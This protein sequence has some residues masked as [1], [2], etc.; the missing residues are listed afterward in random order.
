MVT[1][2]LLEE[3]PANTKYL[4]KVA[5]PNDRYVNVTYCE[6]SS[7]TQCDI[8]DLVTNY[9]SR[10]I[11]WISLVTLHGNCLWSK[12][13]VFSMTESRLLPP[14]LHVAAHSGSVSVKVQSKPKLLKIF[15][16]QVKYTFT[17]RQAGQNNTTLQEKE[18]TCD[19]ACDPYPE[20]KFDGLQWGKEYC[21]NVTVEPLSNPTSNSTK[22]CIYLKPDKFTI[23]TFILIA[24]SASVVVLM[25]A[26]VCFFLCRPAKTPGTLKPLDTKWRPLNINQTPVEV[27]I[28]HGWFLS[29]TTPD[30]TR[31]MSEDKMAILQEEEK[32]ASLDSGVSMVVGS[33]RGSGGGRR[34]VDTETQDNPQEDS[35]CGSLGSSAESESNHG[36]SG[37]LPLEEGRTNGHRV[38]QEEDSGLGLGF[39]SETTG[40]SYGSDCG[41]LPDVEFA[42]GDG[43]RSQSPS[44]IVVGN[45]NDQTTLTLTPAEMHFD[46]A[47][48]MVG[49]RPSQVNVQYSQAPMDDTRQELPVPSYLRKVQAVEAT[50]LADILCLSRQ[51][52]QTGADTMPFIVSFPQ[53]LLN[54]TGEA[55]GLAK[56]PLP[57]TNM[58]LT[59]G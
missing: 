11:V 29:R 3:V 25:L 31:E 36:G 8:S 4:V 33:S 26:G 35:G 38:D 27:V 21:A 22:Q 39:A 45:S 42:I 1:W 20:A 58:E 15:K 9:T 2:Q 13:K 57:L 44:N 55:G 56:L 18:I 40:N 47:A 52:S 41:S 32:R 50:D 17:L 37:M 30:P 53:L 12:K 48:P 46:M 49:Y 51:G 7:L 16:Y 6:N 43:Y 14:I 23:I 10:Y 54:E 34:S 19:A 28:S 5:R 59:F 24:V